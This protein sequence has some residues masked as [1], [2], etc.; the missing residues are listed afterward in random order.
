[1]AVH[2]AA[3]EARSSGSPVP[4]QAR[5][6]S[7]EAGRLDRIQSSIRPR[8]GRARVVGQRRVSVAVLQRGSSSPPSLRGVGQRCR[9]R[10]ASDALSRA[11]CLW[12]GADVAHQAGNSRRSIR[13]ER[14][15]GPPGAWS[16]PPGE[17]REVYRP[18]EYDSTALSVQLRHQ[19]RLTCSGERRRGTRN[20]EDGRIVGVARPGDV[21]P[22]VA[23]GRSTR[24]GAAPPNC[25]SRTSGR[26]SSGVYIIQNAI[27][28]GRMKRQGG[29][30]ASARRGGDES[31][32]ASFSACRRPG[33][34]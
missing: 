20:H 13:M 11:R 2:R 24:S 4:L 23:V 18:G 29:G 15:A 3:L 26:R 10:R 17:I 8:N 31:N 1:M 25:N 9:R 30:G 33:R 32:T 19:E 5:R 7:R 34:T 12:R 21:L 27:S 14:R 28:T 6:A 22:R 16:G